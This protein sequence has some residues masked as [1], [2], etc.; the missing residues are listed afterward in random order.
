LN[1]VCVILAFGIE[2]A[3]SASEVVVFSFAV[4]ALYACRRFWQAVA[5]AGSVSVIAE[6]ELGVAEAGCVAAAAAAAGVPAAGVLA[7]VVVVVE[8]PHAATPN[9]SPAITISLMISF[10]L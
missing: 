5:S 7:G 2:A 1:S 4:N 9:P 3:V 6:L 10:M 8:L